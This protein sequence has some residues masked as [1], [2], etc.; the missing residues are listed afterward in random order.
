[1]AQSTNPSPLGFFLGDALAT[2]GSDAAF[3][4]GNQLSQDDPRN[5]LDLYAGQQRGFAVQLGQSAA[6]RGGS[7]AP[8]VTAGAST[9][10]NG[11]TL[12]IL[13]VVVG[14]ILFAMKK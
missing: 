5:E 4:F 7:V 9:T 6:L 14:V 2:L 3:Y 12:L 8:T 13:V 10:L 11:N 1:M